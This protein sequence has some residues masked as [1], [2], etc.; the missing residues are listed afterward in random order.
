MARKPNPIL[1]A[2]ERKKEAEFAERRKRNSEIDMMAL[3]FSANKELKVGPGRAGFLLAEYIDQ[4]ME[5]AGK[6]LKDDDPELLHTKRDFAWRLK[7]ILGEENW[8][9]YRELFPFCREYWD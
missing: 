9:N 6:L 5:I 1:D 7:N 4:K 8:K 2:F 3:L